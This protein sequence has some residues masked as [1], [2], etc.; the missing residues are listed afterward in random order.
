MGMSEEFLEHI[1]EEFAQ[2]KSDART[3]YRGS[4][5]GMAITKRYVEMMGGQITV[6]S[7]KGEGTTFV[8]ELPLTLA[9]PKE[10]E[11]RYV[12]TSEV[13][14][15]GKRVLLVEDNELNAGIA[16]IQLEKQGLVITRAE[17]GQQ[18]VELFAAQPAG[19][20]DVIL[21]DIMMPI[22]DGYV[23]TQAIRSL[24]ERTDGARIPIIAMTA[25]A[26]A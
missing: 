21:M 20:F 18:A 19:S 16:A 10:K 1:F 15:K 11:R 17:N 2:E 26:F 3:E 13:S 4:G 22:M 23:A 6:S 24:K 9:T 8:V 14:L 25:N 7:T 5:L 12:A